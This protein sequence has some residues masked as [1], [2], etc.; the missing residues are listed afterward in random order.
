[1]RYIA[2]ITSKSQQAELARIKDQL[3][4]SNPILE[5]FGNAKTLRNENSSRFGKYMLLQF[6]YGGIPVGGRITTYLLEK[7]RVVSRAKGERAFHIFYQL[8][9]GASDQLL[10]E[11]HLQRDPARYAYLARSECYKAD[12]TDDKADFKVVSA[13]MKQLNFSAALQTTVWRTIAAILHLGQLKQLEK[14]GPAAACSSSR[15]SRCST[16]PSCSASRSRRSRTRSLCAA[17]T[18]VSL[19]AR[20][21]RR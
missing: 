14:L 21:A 13:A 17:S 6:N 20:R 4:D 5:A 10:G 18:P 19:P 1:M 12:G 9:A 16:P 2:S 15:T 3:L 11:L 8:L 7:S